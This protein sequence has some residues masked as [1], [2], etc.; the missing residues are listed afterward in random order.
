VP[1]YDTPDATIESVWV[2]H[3][4]TQDDKKGMRIHVNFSVYGLKNKTGEVRAYFYHSDGRP[5]KVD[6]WYR[7]KG[8]NTEEGHVGIAEDFKPSYNDSVYE[9]FKLFIP[10]HVFDLGSGSHRL[11]FYVQVYRGGGS[12]YLDEESYS[13]TYTK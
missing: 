5:V 9:D 12:G 11:K 10:Y 2:D 7:G 6:D 3:D 4:V 1:D 13:F 8:Y